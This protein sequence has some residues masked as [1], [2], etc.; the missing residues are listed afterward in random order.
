V[1]FTD[2]VPVNTTYV[3]DSVGLNGLPVGQPDG[4]IS[5]LVSGI[6][7]S[8]SDLTPPLP[9]AGNGTLSLGSTAVVTF[10][11]QVNPGVSEGTIISNQGYVTSN[12]QATEPTDAD[13]IDS[14][15]DQ[16]TQVVVGNSAQV[17]SIL[18]EV[19]VVGGGAAVPGSQLEYVIRV[20]NIGN[21]PATSVVVTDDLG[22]MVGQVT[23]VT[24]SGSLNGRA[25]VTYSG[26]IP[27]LTMPPSPGICHRVQRC[28]A[29]PADQPGA[30]H[31]DHYH[32]YRRRHLERPGADCLGQRI[33]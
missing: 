20:T 29:V 12:E 4:G 1:V 10:D 30:R 16:P 24:G 5:P 9:S 3:P 31:R 32:Q 11:V 22:P 2:A 7:V 23:Y 6:D 28:R 15:G 25:N 19:F 26:A 8:S 18:K 17:L 13:G 33:P 27:P 21:L 14:N